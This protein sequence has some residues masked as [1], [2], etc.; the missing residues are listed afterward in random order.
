MLCSRSASLTSSTRMSSDM[1]EQELAQILGGAL[2]LALRLDL[3]ELGDAVDQPRD[4]LAEQFLDLVVASP[5]CPRS[6]RA[7]SR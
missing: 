7:G 5:A 2:V 6:C 1:R 4:V 3:G